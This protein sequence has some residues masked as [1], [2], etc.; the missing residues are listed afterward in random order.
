MR[1]LYSA[2]NRRRFALATTSV[3]RISIAVAIVDPSIALDT[4]FGHSSCL[5]YVGT[6]GHCQWL[7]ISRSNRRCE[8]GA[9]DGK[10]AEGANE[11]TLPH[12]THS[13]NRAWARQSAEHARAVVAARGQQQRALAQECPEQIAQLLRERLSRLPERSTWPGMVT[14]AS[15]SNDATRRLAAA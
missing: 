14:T 3:S 10:T 7:G 8:H 9:Q 2:V 4:K 12:A 13:I 6:E 5:A 15:G 11:C 1:R